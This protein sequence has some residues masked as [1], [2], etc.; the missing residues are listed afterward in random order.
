VEDDEKKLTAFNA[1]R[2]GP[3]QFW[4]SAYSAAVRQGRIWSSV[5]TTIQATKNAAPS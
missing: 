3:Q 5:T 2:S 1:S 4:N